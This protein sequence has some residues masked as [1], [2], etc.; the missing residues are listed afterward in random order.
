MSLETVVSERSNYISRLTSLLQACASALSGKLRSVVT[1]PL[2]KLTLIGLAIRLALA[3]LT[4]FTY[5]PVVWYSAGNDMLAGLSPYYTK[6]YSYPPLWAYTYFPFLLIASLLV[7]PRTFGTHIAQMDWISLFLGYSPTILSPVFLLAVKLPLII[8]DVVTGLLLY[9]LARGFSSFSISRKAYMFWLFNPLVIWTSAVHGAFDVVPAMFTVLALV[10][11]LRSKYLQTGMSLSIAILYKLYPVYLLPLYAILAWTDLGK[12]RSFRA[13]FRQGKKRIMMFIV[14]GALPLL[15]SLPFVSLND[16]LHTV[17]VRQSYLSSMGGISLWEINS[18]PGFDW[19]WSTVGAHMTLIT[20]TTSAFALG[21]SSVAGWLLVRRGPVET[22]DLVKTH[23][24]GISAIFLSL[25]AVNP[26]YVIWIIPFLTLA[27]YGAG[28]YKKRSLMLTALGLGWQLTISGT[29]ILL[30][31]SYLGLRAQVLT[32]PVQSVLSNSVL[33]F[34]PILLVC[35]LAGGLVTLS[36]VFR[37]DVFSTMTFLRAT[38]V[39]YP[40]SSD[41]FK[42]FRHKI[43]STPGVLLVVF[44]VGLYSTSAIFA[45][46]STIGRFVPTNVNSTLNGDTL[47]THDSFLVDTGKLPL[48]LSLVAAPITSIGKDRPVFIYYDSAY[49]S[50][51][52]E[53]SSWIGIVDHL[54]AELSLRGYSGP[55][56]TVNATGLQ[57]AMTQNLTSIVVIPSGVFP[58]TVQNSTQ[59]LVHAWLMS[60]GVL[61]WMGGPFGFYSEPSLERTIDPKTANM[62]IASQP[63]QQI[64]GLQFGTP[65]L[66]GTSRIAN[67]NTRFSSALNLTYSDVWTAP[68]QGTLKSVGGFAIG[69]TQNSSDTSRSSISLIPVGQ[70]RIILFGGPVGNLLTTDG[71]DVIAHDTAQ[72][73]SLGDLAFAP[74]IQYSTFNL[75][76]GVS[77]LLSFTASF[78]LT[79]TAIHGVALAAFSSY[80]YSRVFWRMQVSAG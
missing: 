77:T 64:L 6:T 50:L 69:H 22:L 31:L 66:N 27:I 24:V 39:S 14:G 56:Q 25:L 51:G 80:G 63:Q 76:P 34:N 35:G 70:G 61:V 79:S 44:I 57:R 65:V 8:A 33:V 40:S 68:T 42:R 54:P 9:K 43:R 18:A 55:V 32:A 21:V 41:G 10:F 11:V 7:D 46:T 17:I 3:P 59:G 12:E 49:P 16:M 36:F 30:P 78:N 48:Q 45:Q 15:F 13:A 20:I 28:V 47:T 37:K 4:Q 72:V 74:Q 62:T 67:L 71:E 38:P 5:D 2:F 75:S 60:G 53:P 52:N 19:V 73:L 58:S 26:Q 29:L 1:H 23:I